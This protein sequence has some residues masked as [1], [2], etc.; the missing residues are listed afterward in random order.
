MFPMILAN[1]L[2]KYAVL[3]LMVFALF[4]GVYMKGRSDGKAVMQASIAKERAKWEQEVAEVQKQFDS[5]LTKI[6]AVYNFQKSKYQTEIKKLK[7][8]KGD[9]KQITKVVEVYVPRSVDTTVPKGF[10]DLHDTAALGLPLKTTSDN[11]NVPSTKKLSDVGTTVATNYYQCNE[12]IAQLEAL[13]LVVAEYRRK[14]QELIG[15]QKK[16]EEDRQK[17]IQRNKDLWSEGSK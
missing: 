16:Q 8:Q 5:E 12:T 3:V 1:P 17:R 10:V 7:S 2:T 14:Q 4:G 13:Q 9:T 6:A 15:K 11:A